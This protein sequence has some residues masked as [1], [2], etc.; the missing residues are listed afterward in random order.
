MNLQ[1]EVE[2]AIAAFATPRN[3]AVAYTGV[4]FTPPTNSRWLEV[5]FFDEQ[6]SNPTVD[7]ERIRK[8]GFFQVNAYVMDG[9][10]LKELTE[11]TEAIVALFPFADKARY[12]TFSVEQTPSVSGTMPDGIYRM[13]AVRVK[14][15]QEF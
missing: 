5:V 12:T 10:G 13:A 11:L 4:P 1:Q 9:K 14:Y 15:R 8:R 7:G 3:I 2:S 6:V